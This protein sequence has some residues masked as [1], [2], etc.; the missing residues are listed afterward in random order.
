MLNDPRFAGPPDP[1]QQAPGF[2]AAG[3]Q[4]PP[5]P[6]NSPTAGA[7]PANPLSSLFDQ[8]LRAI[9]QKPAGQRIE[10][11]D[12]RRMMWA[13]LL[14]DIGQYV[15]SP[16]SYQMRGLGPTYYGNALQYNREATAFNN[17]LDDENSNRAA[18]KLEIMRMKKIIEDKPEII[19]IWQNSGSDKPFM[20]WLKEY[21]EADP[22]NAGTS[23]MQNAAYRAKLVAS[24]ASP[25]ELRRFDLMT[26]TK[27]LPPQ[28]TGTY[29]DYRRDV[30][31]GQFEG[32]YIDWMRESMYG[33]SVGKARGTGE[34]ER[35]QTFITEYQNI[36][37][38]LNQQ[39]SN[40]E[41]LLAALERG[42]YDGTGPIESLYKKYTNADT[43]E[44]AAL[45]MMQTLRNLQITKLTP[46]S[47]EEIALIGR[48]FA[49]IGNDPEGNKGALRAALKMMRDQQGL[50]EQK[51]NYYRDNGATLRGF[52]NAISPELSDDK[53]D[54]AMEATRGK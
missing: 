28:N 10:S 31:S 4:G 37:P 1:R 12:P 32:S 43:A 9:D 19:D 3:Q 23:A 47:N 50:L 11:L 44:L 18:K 16:F 8:A 2:L 33:K 40:A 45:A 35:D 7:P 36:L 52:E 5:A 20:E 49:S 39:I 34:E 13:G 30:E 29:M 27:Q 41:G 14:S 21:K 38:Q 42:E 22:S 6:S 15:A 26:G 53:V 48:M 17:A 51:K 24:G 25:E 46:V 54:A